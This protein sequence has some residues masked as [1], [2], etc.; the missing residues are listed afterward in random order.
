MK[1]GET[2]KDIKTD[3]LQTEEGSSIEAGSHNAK[4]RVVTE[5]ERRAVR[6]LD[7]TIVP[8]MTMFYF[9]SFLV[10]NLIRGSFLNGS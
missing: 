8:V 2:F 5:A 7:Y 9:L 6:K 10:S 3:A 1:M 4:A